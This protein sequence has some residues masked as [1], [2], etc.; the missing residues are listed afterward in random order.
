MKIGF[1]GAGNMGEAYISALASEE[2]FVYEVNDE[3]EEYIKK[4]YKVKATKSIE[5]LVKNSDY[6]LLSVKPQV[7][8]IVLREI[9]EVKGY[10][11][12]VFISIMAGK[13]I[14][15]FEKNLS[16][17]IKMVRVMPNTPALIKKGVSGVCF[18]ENIKEEK[19]DEIL[20]I[21]D[22]TGSSIVIEE[23][24]MDILTAVSGSGPAFVF[25][26]INSLAEGGVKLGMTK[27]MALDLA[28]ETFIG[29]A[30]LIKATG[31]HPEVLKDMVA[32][33]GGTTAAGLFK[34][35]ENGVRKSMIETVEATY[36]RAKELAK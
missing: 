17:Y 33:P 29:S 9:E 7:A 13:T 22:A 4:R 21:I 30:E 10:K 27:K 16:I 28:I 24:M 12:K 20:K 11:E 14:E 8:E 36:N 15:F 3:R 31:K 19:K 23:K 1:I 35:E 34:M 6:I 18:N 32:S 2:I 5:E 25:M 26:L